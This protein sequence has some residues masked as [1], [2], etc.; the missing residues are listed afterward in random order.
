MKNLITL[1]FISTIFLTSCSTQDENDN[2]AMRIA[3]E[4]ITVDFL[5]K[6]KDGSRVTSTYEHGVNELD[7]IVR[8]LDN[9]T[10]VSS[11]VMMTKSDKFVIRVNGN[12][13]M[14]V[15]ITTVDEKN[16]HYTLSNNTITTITLK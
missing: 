16:T 15:V 10:G 6:A 13:P 3:S 11:S 12:K 14:E 7:G 2:A 8:N 5:I 1:A 9:S 4:K